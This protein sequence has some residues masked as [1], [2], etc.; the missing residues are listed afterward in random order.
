MSPEAHVELLRKRGMIV[1]DPTAAA[2][3][4][5]N[6]NYYRLRAY[7]QPF[8][9]NVVTHQFRDGVR[10]DDITRIYQ[11]DSALRRL[12]MVTLE[13]IELSMRARV[14]AEFARQYGPHGHENGDI[15][16][17]YNKW[18]S[19]FRQLKLDL[20]HP[21]DKFVVHFHKK[22][23]DDTPPIW[24]VVETLS[25]G[26]LSYWF[27]HT[28]PRSVQHAIARSLGIH[29]DIIAQW[30]HHLTVVRNIIAHHGRL[31]NRVLP[32]PVKVP[33]TH[34][35]TSVMTSDGRKL[36]NTLVILLYLRNII[37]PDNT[38][39]H[40]LLTLVQLYSIDVSQMGFPNDWMARDVW[41]ESLPS[42]SRE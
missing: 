3:A 39:G 29:A 7:W 33:R 26:T 30:L 21:A 11:F 23:S 5:R 15:A 10:F 18:T 24:A 8:E 32:F 22:Y 16:Y 31:W 1:D 19:A 17:K 25:F 27:K 34:Q 35:T 37:E 13:L 14:A 40:E 41:R 38:W 20:T 6:V 4:L 2:D 12:C 42:L 28:L 9:R 36:Y